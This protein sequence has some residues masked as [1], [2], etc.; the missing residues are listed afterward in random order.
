LR[1]E[2]VLLVEDD[3]LL[4]SL[5]RNILEA[6]GSYSVVEAFDGSHGIEVAKQTRPQII[7]LDVIM[8]G[9][10]GLEALPHLCRL[11]PDARIV[12]LS[13]A[14]DADTVEAAFA[15][16]A[17]GFISKEVSND[18]LVAEVQR[19]ISGPPHQDRALT[20][21]DLIE[22]GPAPANES[23]QSSRR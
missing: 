11:C 16:G 13:M 5:F 12:V 9:M 18:D 1:K 19:A 10:G 7:L 6:S 15:L 22:V 20:L 3:P 17:S 23:G 4:R 14:N 8:P 21:A 2:A